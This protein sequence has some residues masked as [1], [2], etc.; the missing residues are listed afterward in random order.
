MD[1]TLDTF[2]SDKLSTIAFGCHSNILMRSSFD[3]TD[4]IEFTFEGTFSTEA[5]LLSQR[6]ESL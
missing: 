6:D 4:C 5:Q 2:S 3:N 1:Q